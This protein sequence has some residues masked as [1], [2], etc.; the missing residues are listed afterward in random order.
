MKKRAAN[1]QRLQTRKSCHTGKRQAKKRV[2][3]APKSRGE[4]LVCELFKTI[5]HFFPDLFEQLRQ[6]E[7]CRQKSDYALAEL[8]MAGIALF[9]FQQGSRNAFNN[10]AQEGKF[11]KH[12]QK[13]FRL[14]LPIWTRCTGSCVGWLRRP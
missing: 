9:L 14:R 7:D 3:P 2:S 10:K 13:L 4:A 8:L 6:V 12:Y 11:K 1:L 5:H